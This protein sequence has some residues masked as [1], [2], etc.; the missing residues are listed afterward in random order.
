MDEEIKARLYSLIADAL[1]RVGMGIIELR[2]A[3]RILA[4]LLDV[5]EPDDQD[6]DDDEDWSF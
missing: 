1:D 4:G 2:N 6:E 3:R 5:L